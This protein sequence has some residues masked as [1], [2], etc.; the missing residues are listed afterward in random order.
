MVAKNGGRGKWIEGG[1]LI[2]CPDADEK[3]ALDLSVI[4]MLLYLKY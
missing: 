1:G 4:H 3:I 2:V